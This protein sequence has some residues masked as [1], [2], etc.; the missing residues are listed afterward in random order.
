MY[1]VLRKTITIQDAELAVAEIETG[2]HNPNNLIHKMFSQKRDVVRYLAD[3][4]EVL[5]DNNK[6]D[7]QVNQIANYLMK[8]IESSNADI[9]KVWVYDSLPAKYKTHRLLQTKEELT[10]FTENSSLNTN[11]EQENQAEITFVEQ[12]IS[13]LKLRLSK[14]RSSH[15]YSKLEP[16]QYREHYIIRQAAQKFMSDALDDRKTVP[17]NTIHLLV[18]AYDTSNLK[19]SAGEYIS[20]LKLFGAQKKDEGIKTLSKIFTSKQMGKI[21]R[22]LTRELHQSLE[23]LT[24]DDAYANGFY[25]K[26]NCEE[27]GSWRIE[28]HT[29]YD[30]K[31][32]NFRTPILSCFKCGHMSESPKV[33]LP[34]STATPRIIEEKVY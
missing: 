5:I 28:L 17:L 34:I 22:G 11:Y 29:P 21:L 16:E 18:T 3:C 24:Q 32:G 25:G 10:H 27:C 26:T 2:I 12:E 30:Y 6:L 1:T 13:L 20:E 8:K 33:K 19:H 15:Y 31:L 4:Y 7:V 9:T 23:I 14:L